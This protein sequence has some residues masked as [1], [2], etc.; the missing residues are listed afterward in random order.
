MISEPKLKLVEDFLASFSKEELI[1]LNGYVNGFVANNVKQS[2]NNGHAN[3][4][5]TIAFATETGNSKKLATE[6]T[7]LAKQKGQVTKL[8]SIDQYKLNDLEKEE[9]LFLIIST[10]GEGEPPATAK[11]FYDHIHNEKH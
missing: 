5:I 6:L 2:N 1:W 7:T 10:Q 8:I 9:Y 4:K 3:K 11:R